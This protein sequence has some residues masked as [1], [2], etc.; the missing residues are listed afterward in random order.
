MV[1]QTITVYNAGEGGRSMLLHVI[2]AVVCVNWR[3]KN[4]NCKSLLKARNTRH[5]LGYVPSDL[6]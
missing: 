1:N 4:S 5:S 3:K 6:R 2:S